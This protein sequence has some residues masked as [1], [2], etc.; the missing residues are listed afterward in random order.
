MT[1][2]TELQRK[3]ADG[4]SITLVNAYDFATAKLVDQSEVDIILVGD[5][6]GVTMLGYPGTDRVTLDEIIHHASAVTRA[7]E[8][9]FV[10]V[11][12]PFGAYN[13]TPEEAV[14]NANRL[15]KE[16]GADGIKLEGGQE[17]AEAVEA[18][19][20]A[21]ITVFGHMGVTPQT[22]DATDG[23]AVQGQTSTE[24]DELLEDARAVDEA[25]AVGMILELV[26][27]EAAGTVTDATKG[28]TIG[29][30]AGPHCNA[31]AVTLHD[32][33]GLY[34]VLPATAEG[35]SANFGGEIVE[36][37]DSYDEA[38]DSGEFPQ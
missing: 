34:D 1:S 12:L 38:V 16:G 17:V 6:L 27:S 7:V 2:L 20:A 24:A 22:D 28:I 11:D 4:E 33:L 32:L 25:G 31:Q 18:I 10:M 19:D 26:D 35:V 21:G 13:V 30:G 9:T 3:A 36:H 29:I 8:D 23:Y 14:R 5:S 37:L 15:K